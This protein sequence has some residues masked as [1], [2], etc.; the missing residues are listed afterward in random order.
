MVILQRLLTSHHDEAQ[1]RVHARLLRH[2]SPIPMQPR[3]VQLLVRR[4]GCRIRPQTSRPRRLDNGA[5]RLAPLPSVLNG[6]CEPGLLTV[7]TSAR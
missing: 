3:A 7:A 4:A 6:G 5:R 1:D 2:F